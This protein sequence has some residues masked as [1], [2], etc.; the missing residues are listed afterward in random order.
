MAAEM[1]W[2]VYEKLYCPKKKNNENDEYA[3]GIN[4]VQVMVASYTHITGN[5]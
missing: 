5:E 4:Q 1:N 2:V 3:A